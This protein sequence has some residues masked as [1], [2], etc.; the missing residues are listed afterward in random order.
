MSKNDS[1]HSSRHDSQASSGVSS[2]DSSHQVPA[3]VDADDSLAP[4]PLAV[5]EPG[6]ADNTGEWLRGKVELN[7]ESRI[8][9][10]FQW[11]GSVPNRLTNGWTKLPIKT[12]HHINGRFSSRGNGQGGRMVRQSARLLIVIALAAAIIVVIA[13]A[14]VRIANVIT[15]AASDNTTQTNTASPTPASAITI[16]NTGSDVTPPAKPDYTFGMWASNFMPSNGSNVTIYGRVCH[17]ETG[18]PGVPGLQVTL[19]I[20]GRV[21][22]STTNGDG[23]AIFQLQAT[24]ASQRPVYIYGSVVI[25]GHEYKES[26]FY[27]PI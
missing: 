9:P 4:A 18:L 8:V 12:R 26:T 19:N 14:S 5:S 22:T 3:L 7:W 16:R 2:Q 24:G 23:L 11:V 27:T 20:N 15:H 17:N 25:N 10:F 21:M 13:A 6:W 1:K